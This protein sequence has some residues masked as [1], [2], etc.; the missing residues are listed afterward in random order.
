MLEEVTTNQGLGEKR[1]WLDMENLTT[2]MAKMFA[3]EWYDQI[4]SRGIEYQHMV[5]SKIV[6]HPIWKAIMPNYNEMERVFDI[7]GNISQG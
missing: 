2:K 1:S 5:W 4:A 7:V 3:I 6:K